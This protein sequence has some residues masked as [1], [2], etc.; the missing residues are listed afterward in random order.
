[1]IWW[2]DTGPGT[3]ALAEATAPHGQGLSAGHDVASLS[4]SV[5]TLMAARLGPND[6]IWTVTYDGLPAQ[7]VEVRPG[8]G[9]I[10]ESVPT[11]FGVGFAQLAF[12]G[13]QAVMTVE[14]YGDISTPPYYAT[15]SSGGAWS[16]FKPVAGTWAS[17]AAAALTTTGHGLR[18]ITGVGNASYRPVVAGWNGSGFGKPLLTPDKNGCGVKTHDG[19]AD[20][21]QRLLDVSWECTDLAVANYPDAIHP[22][23]FRLKQSATPTY[24]AQI[25]SGTRGIATLVYT[26]ENGTANDLNV[27]HVLL[28]DS[29]RTVAKRS[30]AGRV[31][32][33]GPR[34]CLPPVNVHVGWTHRAARGWRFASGF[35]RLGAAAVGGTLDGAV[36]TPGKQYTLTGTAVFSKAGARRSVTATL[37]FKS[38]AAA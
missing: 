37:K 33:T 14:K 34:S 12:V 15:R 20:P 9:A 10:A 1:V 24:V 2:H 31:T 26:V 32:V 3:A 6:S 28:P 4:S 7:H 25:A 38:C 16:D 5:G 22:A 29:T 11:P 17:G 13:G 36:L 18:I 30:S 21:S 19:W 35:L 23:L 27:A 8:L